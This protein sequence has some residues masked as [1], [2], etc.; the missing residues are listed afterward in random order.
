MQTST[1]VPGN[2][3]TQVKK[4]PLQV[5][6]QL[7]SNYNAQA[8]WFSWNVMWSIKGELNPENNMA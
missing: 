1:V 6:T 5:N 8:W 4:S 7:T 3:I 2:V